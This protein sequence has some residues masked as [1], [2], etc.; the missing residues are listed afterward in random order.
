MLK[1]DDPKGAYNIAHDFKGKNYTY[2]K[3]IMYVHLLSIDKNMWCVV[4]EGPYIP[5]CAND[6]V[7]SPKDWDD[8]ENK[9]A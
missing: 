4:T 8:V 7:K 9:K 6:I 2:W 1:D 5:K 3:S